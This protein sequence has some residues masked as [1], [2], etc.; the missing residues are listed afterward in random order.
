MASTHI[1]LGETNL[2]N[3]KKLSEIAMLLSGELS[4]LVKQFKKETH[5]IFQV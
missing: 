4:P 5:G 2:V 1:R 3:I